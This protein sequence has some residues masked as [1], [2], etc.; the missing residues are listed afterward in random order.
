MLLVL[1]I[2]RCD[3]P[4]FMAPQTRSSRPDWPTPDT[5]SEFISFFGRVK[6]LRARKASSSDERSFHGYST[7]LRKGRITTIVTKTTE[8]KDWLG[9][10]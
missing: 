9:R 4:P 3:V 1:Q 10:F 7:I 6:E 5:G 2:P 8:W